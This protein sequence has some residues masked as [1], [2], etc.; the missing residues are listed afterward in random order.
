L[1]RLL[2]LF[3]LAFP[4]RLISLPPIPRSYFSSMC[5][6]FLLSHTPNHLFFSERSLFFLPCYDVYFPPFLPWIVSLT[7]SLLSGRCNMLINTHVFHSHHPFTF[8]CPKSSPSSLS[9]A[10]RAGFV[11]AS[12]ARTLYFFFPLLSYVF[13]DFVSLLSPNLVSYVLFLEKTIP[14]PPHDPPLRI[15]PIPHEFGFHLFFSRSP[16]RPFVRVGST[17]LHPSASALI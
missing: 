7:G 17:T 12:P 5:F 8:F 2:L 14:S 13:P 3:S 15:D 9:P 11:K 6:F 4:I 16:A 1:W 10:P